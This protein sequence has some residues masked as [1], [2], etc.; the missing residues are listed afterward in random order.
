[1]RARPVRAAELHSHALG[2]DDLDVFGAEWECD[3]L[4]VVELG[5]LQELGFVLGQFL[6]HLLLELTIYIISHLYN[7]NVGSPGYRAQKGG[8]HRPETAGG[9]NHRK[10]KSDREVRHTIST[11]SITQKRIKFL[12]KEIDEL[13]L[14]N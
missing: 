14:N 4:D 5:P 1:M 10:Q 13:K 8:R 9:Q 6:E 3:V 12:K 11:P 2:I 7:L